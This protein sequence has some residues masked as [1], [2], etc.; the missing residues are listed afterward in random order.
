MSALINLDLLRVSI[1][2]S[3][4]LDTEKIMKN[5]KDLVQSS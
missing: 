5:E 4:I 3:A 2:Q 1:V